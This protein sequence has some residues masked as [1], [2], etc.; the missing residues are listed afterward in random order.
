M[1]EEEEEK[2]NSG[3]VFTDLPSALGNY[4]KWPYYEDAWHSIWS[5]PFIT[6]LDKI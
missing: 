6:A 4:I 3:G 1:L 5:I 2:R